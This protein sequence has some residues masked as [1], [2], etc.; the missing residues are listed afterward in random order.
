MTT[1]QPADIAP[2]PP[3]TAQPETA[4]SL[5]LCGDPSPARVLHPAVAEKTRWFTHAHLPPHLAAVSAVFTRAM[6]EVLEHP[7]A[8][9]Q[10]TI[11]L[12]HLLEA[13]DAAVRAAISAHDDAG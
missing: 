6:H 7:L 1:E 12:Q 8:G 9:P 5:G 10:A 13:K 2:A 11:A 4:G 3:E